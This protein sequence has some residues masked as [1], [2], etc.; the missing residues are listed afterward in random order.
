M[1]AP[2]KKAWKPKLHPLEVADFLCF[3]CP[4]QFACFC[5]VKSSHRLFRGI[6]ARTASLFRFHIETMS[7]P[8]PNASP[9][10]DNLLR[11]SVVTPD[12]SEIFKNHSEAK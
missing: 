9:D 3:R 1:Q 8:A 5:E 2:P 4:S 6:S 12:G 10:S 11:E 7:I